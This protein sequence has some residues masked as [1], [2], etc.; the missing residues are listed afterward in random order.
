VTE[1]Q[2]GLFRVDGYSWD[3]LDFEERDQFVTGFLTGT[4]RGKPGRLYGIPNSV[5]AEDSVWGRFA[6]Q[7]NETLTDYRPTAL[8]T[9]PFSTEALTY[10][11]YWFVMWFDLNVCALQQ[12]RLPRTK[13][14]TNQE[15]ARDFEEAL[16]QA[17]IPVTGRLVGLRPYDD[18]TN[19]AELLELIHS[20]R[21]LRI[22]VGSLAGRSVPA[23]VDLTNPRPDANGIL[24]EY[25][26]HDYRSGVSEV[27]VRVA[28]EDP[29]ADAKLSFY[30]KAALA[31]GILE[32]VEVDVGGRTIRRVREER[33]A[34]I[35][36]EEPLTE[37]TVEDL[38]RRIR[39]NEYELVAVEY[40]PTL[41]G[42][43]G[44]A[45]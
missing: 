1:A 15:V 40:Q 24:H 28:P 11:H 44:V 16:S 10:E 34:S 20:G 5:R 3:Q 31:T 6:H 39:L 45:E 36:V 19:E 12:R 38:Q 35:K 22:R 23:G 25:V 17:S 37:K 21:V 13:D 27:S 43:T 41:F 26:D 32:E 14:L 8:G 18:A 30:A 29:G 42:P 2:L 9:E 33:R 7:T 4:F